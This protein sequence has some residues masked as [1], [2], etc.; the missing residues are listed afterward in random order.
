MYQLRHLPDLG[1]QLFQTLFR[2]I[3]TVAGIAWLDP[4]STLLAVLVAVLVVGLPLLLQAPLR[5]WDLRVRTH[6]GALSRFYL[7]ALLGLMA[8]RAHSAER[9]LRREHE[10]LLVTW[11][12]ASLN[13]LRLT[14]S[15]E[16]LQ[17]LIAFALV[18]L[19]LVNY[20]PQAGQ[21]G[22]ILLLVYWAPDPA[23]AGP[24]GSLA[25]STISGPAQPG[26]A[27]DGAAWRTGRC[28]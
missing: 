21:A 14:V 4:S 15:L 11:T 2:L 20:R 9:S 27:L 26:P 17:F 22:S 16:G 23:D 13:L 8:V 10:K 3:V 1:R 6:L 28:R 7:D 18:G 25:D 19:L 24:A 5:E 12:E